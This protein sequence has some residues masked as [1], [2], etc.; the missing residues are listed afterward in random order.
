MKRDTVTSHIA[1]RA[2]EHRL[3]VAGFSTLPSVARRQNRTSELGWIDTGI[4][5]PLTDGGTDDQAYGTHTVIALIELL[6]RAG[7]AVR[8]CSALVLACLT[9]GGLQAGALLVRGQRCNEYASTV[10][11]GIVN[12]TAQRACAIIWQQSDG[13]GKQRRPRLEI[14]IGE[15][16]HRSRQAS[17]QAVNDGDDTH[18]TGCVQYPA[19]ALRYLSNRS[20]R[21]W[22]TGI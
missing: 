8:H 17:M 15:C 14:D 13:V 12:D 4:I 2:F 19:R 16:G 10:V 22:R 7:N 11:Q 20:A 9:N 6:S 5:D 18:L 1:F 21:T 3:E